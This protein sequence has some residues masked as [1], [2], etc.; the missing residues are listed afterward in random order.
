MGLLLLVIRNLLLMPAL[1]LNKP[2]F[3]PV[4]GIASFSP[5]S[6]VSKGT[7]LFL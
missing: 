1:K 5:A 2:D 6:N 4:L 7:L 3:R